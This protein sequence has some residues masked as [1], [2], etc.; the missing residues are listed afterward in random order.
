V[1]FLLIAGLVL[2]FNKGIAQV[3][4]FD[5]WHDGK[6][7]LE[8]GDTLAGVLKYDLNDLLQVKHHNRLESFSARKVLFFEIFDQTYKRYRQFY[9]LPFALEGQYRTPVFFE[10][11]NEGKLTVLTRERVEYRSYSS[12][13]YYSSF[14]SRPVL[15]N[16]FYLLKENGNIEQFAARKNDWYDV[17][18]PK[19]DEVHDFAKENRLS[20]DNKY[21]LKIIIDHYNSLFPPK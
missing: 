7:V 12:P 20:F 11:L 16:V 19:A 14:Y 13:Y 9:S 5:F 10:L 18:G 1:K 17:M 15:V 4:P 3:F 21:Q 8:S 6:V 2:F